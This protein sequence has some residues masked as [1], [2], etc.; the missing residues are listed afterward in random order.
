VV[1]AEILQDELGVLKQFISRAGKKTRVIVVANHKDSGFLDHAIRCG[2]KG[3]IHSECPV[4]EIPTAIR[5]VTSGGVWR[6]RAAA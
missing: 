2:A 1:T 3:V 4:E 6:E 5:K